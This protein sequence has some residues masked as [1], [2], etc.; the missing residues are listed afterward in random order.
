MVV[1]VVDKYDLVVGES[2]GVNGRLVMGN[3]IVSRNDKLIE[4]NL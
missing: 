4:V 3:V 1:V 2:S